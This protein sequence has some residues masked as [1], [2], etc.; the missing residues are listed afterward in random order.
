MNSL[1]ASSLAAAA[2]EALR[3][4]LHNVRYMSED[5]AFQAGVSALATVLQMKVKWSLFGS[6]LA[7]RES[8]IVLLRAVLASAFQNRS[9]M[10]AL[11]AGL[12]SALSDTMALMLLPTLSP[13]ISSL[14]DNSRALV[15][16]PTQP[17]RT[18]TA[19]GAETATGSTNGNPAWPRPNSA[20]MPPP[21]T[22][23]FFDPGRVTSPGFAGAIG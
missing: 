22:T 20:P 13:V 4:Y 10:F 18:P 11:T 9:S 14:V 19:S 6:E 21:N 7:A 15:V 8:A 23:P 1:L 5:A 17:P 2:V 12:D 16:V 3:G